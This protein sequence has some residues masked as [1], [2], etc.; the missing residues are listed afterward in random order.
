MVVCLDNANN[1]YERY[2]YFAPDGVEYPL[3]VKRK[4]FVLSAEGEGLPPINYNTQRGPFQDGETMHNFFAQPRLV[5]LTIRHVLE[6]RGEYWNERNSLM[7]ALN[8]LKQT[9]AYDRLHGVLRKVLPG[10]AKRD[11]SCL[12]AQGPNFNPRS[13]TQWDEYAYQE[14]LRFIAHDPIYY[15]PNEITVTFLDSQGT[16]ITFPITFPIQF[17]D[18]SETNSI[19]YQ[20]SWREYPRI[21]FTGPMSVGRVYN[22]TTDEQI[23]ITYPLAAGDTITVDLRY[24]YKTVRLANGTSVL[25]Y[26]TADSDLGSF[27]LTTANGGVNSVV[28][29]AYGSTG[30]TRIALKY[31]TRYLGI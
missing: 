12:I 14:V 4:R 9:L 13:L 31:N 30:A 8:P 7:Y 10:G 2:T 23:V 16:D 11:L 6:T 18:I 28:G 27:H 17:S 29:S 19:N 22:E 20:G 26:I 15:D 3:E 1:T 24:G 21:V 5:Q 25:G